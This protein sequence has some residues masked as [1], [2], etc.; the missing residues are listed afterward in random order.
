MFYSQRKEKLLSMVRKYGTFRYIP[1]RQERIAFCNTIMSSLEVSE[2]T[3]Y[4]NPG[5]FGAIP[6][7]FSC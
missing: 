6:I 3:T 5:A 2:L 4:G 1:V 7:T